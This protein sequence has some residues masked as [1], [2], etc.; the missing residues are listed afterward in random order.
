VTHLK[1]WT[2]IGMVR[3]DILLRAKPW[4]LLLHRYG[5]RHMGDLNTSWKERLSAALSGTVLFSLPLAILGVMPFL[6]PP[7]VLLLFVILQYGFYAFMLNRHRL[8][9]WPSVFLL[10]H[11]Y[12]LSAIGGWLLARIQII[13]N[14]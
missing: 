10:H 11:V 13:R 8:V 4:T 3:T 12:F 7:I 5:N 6:V 1:R 2:F 9:D 14:R